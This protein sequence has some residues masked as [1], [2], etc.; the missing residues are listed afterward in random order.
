[1]NN[2]KTSKFYKF[3]KI[4]DNFTDKVLLFCFLC[5][6]LIGLYGVYDSYM[7]YMNANDTSILKYKPTDDVL[8]DDKK[9]SD[10]MVAWLIMDDTTIDY[11]VMQGET[12]N[13]YLNK[14][15][16]GEYSLSGAIVLDSNNSKN[17]DDGYSLIYGHHMENKGMF[18]VLDKYLDATFLEKHKTG[19]LVI[20][21]KTLSLHVFAVLDVSATNNYVFNPTEH[22]VEDVLTEM[23]QYATYWDSSTNTQ[24]KQIIALSTCKSPT[25]DL[26]TVVVCYAE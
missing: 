9:I 15:P 8:P 6:I 12:N 1:M 2:T 21:D 18:G 17:F 24:N 19:K 3:I 4:C 23:Q 5:F 22:P 25:T 20:S 11:P 16:Y 26:R 10:D 7:V 14:N 13:E